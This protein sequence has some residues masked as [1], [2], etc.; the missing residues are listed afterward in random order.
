M[1]ADTGLSH[2]RYFI[3]QLTTTGDWYIVPAERRCEWDDLDIACERTSEVL[4]VPT[5]AARLDD[6]P[7]WLEFEGPV[8]LSLE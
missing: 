3:D 5:W 1:H 4:P 2:A 6:G 8:D 7:R